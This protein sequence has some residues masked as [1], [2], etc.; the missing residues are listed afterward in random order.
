MGFNLNNL[1]LTLRTSSMKNEQYLI[2]ILNKIEHI[3]SEIW[4][5][6]QYYPNIYFMQG[7]SIKSK[8]LQKIRIKKAKIIII[9]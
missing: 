3:P 2:L 6:I 1:L 4:K 8:E 9:Q 5:E 7:N